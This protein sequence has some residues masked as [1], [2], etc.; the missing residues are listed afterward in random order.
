MQQL[1]LADE[2]ELLDATVLRQP[3]AYPGYFGSAFEHFGELRA[4]LDG[5]DNLYLCGYCTLR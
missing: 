3:K 5:L 1:G 4:W 2:A